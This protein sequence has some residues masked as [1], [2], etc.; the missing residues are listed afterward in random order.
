MKYAYLLPALLICGCADNNES[1]D[2]DRFLFVSQTT[3]CVADPSN[4]ANRGRGLLDVGIVTLGASQGVQG[5][6]AAPVVRNNMPLRAA[7]GEIDQDAVIVTSFD[8]ELR[9]DPT[10][11]AVL[12]LSQT[13]FNVPVAGG[14]IEAGGTSTNAMFVELIPASVARQMATVVKP[15]NATN[16]PLV[17]AH[18]RAVVTKV[19]G[20]TMNSG[21][22]DFPI[23]I[24][25]FCLTPT[26][27]PC[28]QVPFAM[29]SVE[30]SGC[31]VEQDDPVTC[32]TETGNVLLCGSAVP[33][34]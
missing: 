8:V 27:Q 24:C 34:Q 14:R 20:S 11:A 30:Q 31:I 12:P 25:N 2:I 22:T 15:G 3:G 16:L 26:P 23:D 5:Y 4:T 33:Q 6:I 10:I 1:V 9:P 7:M 17:V 28:P 21:W 13:A 29:A 32:C 18:T 19:D